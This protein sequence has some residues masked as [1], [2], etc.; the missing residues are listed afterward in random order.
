MIEPRNII[1]YE[2]LEPLSN[3]TRE[4]GV[5]KVYHKICLLSLDNQLCHKHIGYNLFTKET[6]PL[7]SR[8]DG[9][10]NVHEINYLEYKE[11]NNDND[12][13]YEQFVAEHQENFLKW[14]RKHICDPTV[15]IF[16]PK[17]SEEIYPFDRK[18]FI[19][20][21]TMDNYDI[22]FMVYV[23][24]NIVYIYGRTDDVVLDDN[25]DDNIF[26]KLITIF[27]IKNICREKPI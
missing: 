5:R 12:I 11:D 25:D 15:T 1:K 24:D 18:K 19:L 9:W 26:D 16:T 20:Y 3:R 7:P 4:E 27:S 21:K 8:N 17:S 13:T 14:I 23:S 10:I 6:Y 2:R 22:G